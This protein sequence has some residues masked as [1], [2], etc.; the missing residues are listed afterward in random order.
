MPN[1]FSPKHNLEAFNRLSKYN[2]T[3]QELEQFK[4]YVQAADD[5]VLTRVNPRY[6]AK[7]IHWSDTRTLDLLTLAAAENLWRFKWDT[8]CPGCGGLLQ[9]TPELGQVAS[10]QVCPMCQWE[11]DII[12]DQMVTVYASLD[13]SVRKLNPP[14][15]GDDAFRKQVD[16]EFGQVLA[17]TLINRPLFREVLGNQVL[18][19]NQS[20]GVQ[21]LAVFFSDL[22]SST[23]LYQRLGD[24]AAYQLVRQHFLAI[25]A[26]VETHGG[27]AVKTIGDGIMG[28]F[29]NNGAALLGI[30]E[31]VQAINELNQ[32]AGLRGENRLRLKVGLHAGPC[33]VVTLNHR[34]DYFGSTVN[35]ASR[36]SHLS[37]G[38]DLW[39][40]E[41]VLQDPEAAR[42]VRSMGIPE[43][44]TTTLRG[45]S[46]PMNIQRIVFPG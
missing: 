23:A 35:I 44:L 4:A 39:L 10:H 1:W 15:Q 13:P 6:L 34:L 12:L 26:A 36:L 38:D 5:K 28:T 40:S 17:L 29:L 3:S 20:L 46:I 24:A 27:S 22:K 9:H 42:I 16:A 19:H 14:G 25:F 43:K 21:H 37:E 8:F 41:A 11:G 33:I 18:P 32:Q 45:L 7:K 2:I 31:S 30:I